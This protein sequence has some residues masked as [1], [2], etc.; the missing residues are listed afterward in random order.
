MSENMFPLVR[1]SDHQQGCPVQYR[2]SLMILGDSIQKTTR[3]GA[4]TRFSQRDYKIR[5]ESALCATALAK[6]H[7]RVICLFSNRHLLFYL[8]RIVKSRV[9]VFF[10]PFC[11][12]SSKLTDGYLYFD[13]PLCMYVSTCG[14]GLPCLANFFPQSRQKCMRR[15][16]R[17]HLP[18]AIF[19]EQL[20]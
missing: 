18:G 13:P 11:S 15:G 20:T 1:L 3:R 7:P 2:I 8:R 9:S 10:W 4:R 17:Y 12:S 14:L 19:Y 5:S 6:Q 16:S